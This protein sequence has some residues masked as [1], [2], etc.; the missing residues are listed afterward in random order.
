MA[1]ITVTIPDAQAVRVRDAVCTHYG[2]QATIN[3]APNPET[4]AQFVSRKVREFLVSI[5]RGEEVKA[6]VNT[7]SATT[8]AAVDA[9]FV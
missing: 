9:D 5:V 1:Q 7:T 4:K 6:A 8:A 3:G 2:Y